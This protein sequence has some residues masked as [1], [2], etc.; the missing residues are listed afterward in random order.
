MTPAYKPSSPIVLV[1]CTV[2]EVN[3]STSV[4]AA[5]CNL[6]YF[7]GS[8][9]LPFQCAGLQALIRD[10]KLWCNIQGTDKVV[11]YDLV[12]KS[13]SHRIS[14][15]RW[16]NSFWTGLLPMSTLPTTS[17]WPHVGCSPCPHPACVW[18]HIWTFSCPHSVSDPTSDPYPTPLCAWLRPHVAP[19]LPISHLPMPISPLL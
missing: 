1:N 11:I 12:K 2:C 15:S 19:A 4:S 6:I 16:A 3:E 5:E 13:E 18:P 17:A 9:Y 8:Q 14:F 10:N 7:Q